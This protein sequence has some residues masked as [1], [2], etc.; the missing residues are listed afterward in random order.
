[1]KDRASDRQSDQRVMTFLLV[2]RFPM[3]S[4]ASAADTM[5][6]ANET[7]DREFYKWTTV[8]VDGEPVMASNGMKLNVD[9]SLRNQPRPDILFVCAGTAIDFPEKPAVL[10][11]LR[12]WGR[13]GWTLGALTLGS[14][15]LAEAGQLAGH[16]CTIH[17][18]NRAGFRETF[19]D[20]ECTSNV[21][22]I[23]RNRYT[24]AGGTTSMDLFLEIIR[25]DLGLA[26]ANEVAGQFQHE[27]VR[28]PADRQRLG[29]GRDLTSK[30]VVL[31]RIIE[32]MAEKLEH[33]VSVVELA[34]EGG[35]SVRQMERLFASHVETTPGRYYVV[36]RLERA[37]ALLRQ[38][39]MS[40][41][42]VALATGFASQSYF[43]HSF[44]QKFGYLPSKERRPAR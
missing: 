13:L 44:R 36:L 2:D 31:R 35:L 5:R 8:S 22:E 21:Y 14:H 19:P 38:T 39:P 17:W 27:R 18:Q 7:F 29:P 10:S 24:S 42:A 41:L 30:P 33:P 15:V 12:Q 16:R 37:R 34:K 9:C 26:I 6:T 11:A 23:D 43:A 25:R 40:I 4:L 28:S 1:M 3:F 32:L 20:I